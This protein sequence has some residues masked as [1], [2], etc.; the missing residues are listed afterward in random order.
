MSTSHLCQNRLKT[1]ALNAE[2]RFNTLKG[3]RVKWNKEQKRMEDF[4]T[5]F[6]MK[7]RFDNEGNVF[8]LI[9]TKL[10]CVIDKESFG[11]D[12]FVCVD[13]YANE[14]TFSYSEVE[15]IEK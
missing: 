15:R 13:N 12:E 11:V 1:K 14:F 3:N 9:N 7:K 6:E 2:K 10:Y 4:I 5:K 8:V